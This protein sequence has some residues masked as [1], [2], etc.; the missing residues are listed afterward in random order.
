[1]KASL[2]V[3]AGGSGS[4]LGGVPKQFR[5]LAGMPVWEWSVRAAAA[6][7]IDDILLVHPPE[8]SPGTS[9]LPQGVPLRLVPGGA[10]RADS[11]RAGVLAARRDWVLIHDAARPFLSPSLLGRLLGA[12]ERGA[13]AVPILPVSDALKRIEPG[14]TV[15]SVSREGLFRAQTPQS[16]PREPLIEVLGV[17]GA[18]SDEA[19]AWLAAGRPLETVEGD[20]MNF[21]IT[22]ASDWELARR[23]A[24]VP[25]ERRTGHGYDL[26]PLVPERPLVLGGILLDSPLGLAG[27]SDADLL[28]HAVADAL[29]GAAGEPDIGLLFPASDPAYRGADSRE[30]L[31]ACARR[32]R[33]RGWR[34]VWVDATLI[35]QVPRLAEHLPRIRA[36]LGEILEE[37]GPEGRFNLK[38]KSGEGCGSAGRGECMICHVVAT[39]EKRGVGP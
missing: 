23:L 5:L 8:V 34:V 38:V 15:R 28:C 4:R 2:V 30:L 7:G 10:R 16:F 17:G 20:P 12:A 39:I 36:S 18:V 35:A 33:D 14:G 22:D 11:S 25:G 19:E 9:G 6:A 26:H 31:R 1:V 21:K 37:A 13:A 32:V 24:D 3:V 27:H 29:L